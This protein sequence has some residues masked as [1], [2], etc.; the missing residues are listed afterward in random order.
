MSA[1]Q[2]IAGTKALEAIREQGLTAELFDY[3]LGASGGPKWFVLAG[4]DRVMMPSFFTGRQRPLDIV[5][6]SAGSFRFACY[7]QQDPFS[8]INRL[9]EHYSQTVYSDKPDRQEISEKSWQLM[10]HFLGTTGAQEIVNNPVVRAHFVV[11]KS[12]GLIAS[13]RIPLQVT[14]ILASAI[15]NRLSRKSLD[16]FYQ[17]HVFSSQHSSL[18]FDDPWQLKLHQ[19]ALTEA[20]LPKALMAS[21]SI[22]VVLAGIKDIPT[23]L[24][25]CIATEASLTTIL[26][27]RYPV[28]TS[29]KA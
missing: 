6:S 1:L 18:E 10:D 28:R 2:L 20:N 25:V 19:H 4:L 26:I 9:A 14:G 15:A 12:K 8:A 5:G 13:E 17:R 24:W 3:M 29:N 16:W 21:G 22:P 7:A 23:R 11:A 27:W